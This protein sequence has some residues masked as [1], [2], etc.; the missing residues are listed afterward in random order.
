[1]KKNF[2]LAAVLLCLCLVCGS[3][4]A[5]PVFA[6]P[7]VII[8][9]DFENYKIDDVPEL[10]T[11]SHDVK[12]D[13]LWGGV[14]EDPDNP[15][16]KVMAISSTGT[17]VKGTI[18]FKP[19]GGTVSVKYKMR[20]PYLYNDC[21]YLGIMDG[22]V[23]ILTYQNTWNLW[24]GQQQIV[25]PNT[26]VVYDT[27]LDMEYVIR[28]DEQTFDILC[29]GTHWIENY[30]FYIADIESID[31]IYWRNG[32]NGILYI[33]DVVITNDGEIK[34]IY[35]KLESS[36]YNVYPSQETVKNIGFET[37]VKEFMSNMKFVE[38]A[39]V[40]ILNPDGTPY[41]GRYIVKNLLLDVSSPEGDQQKIFQIHSRPWM[42]SLVTVDYCKDAIIFCKNSNDAMIKGNKNYINPDDLEVMPFEE[43]GKIYLPLRFIAEQRGYTVEWIEDEE[44]VKFGDVKLVEKSS[45][46]T[47]NSQKLNV[48]GNC[49]NKNGTM[50]V[51]SDWIDEIFDVQVRAYKNFLIIKDDVSFANSRMEKLALNEIAARYN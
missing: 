45:S 12:A 42:A 23:R 13:G 5:A 40:K 8:N 19:L 22:I 4:A 7:E 11:V 30:K 46:V 15:D 17:L 32:A 6:E 50:Y 51:P 16:N 49:I 2:K 25:L 48:D 33:D 20:I 1:M 26:P 10:W 31:H 18:G 47:K 14:A 44:A 34:T 41:A 21:H 28:F 27:W 9:Q 37:P 3:F 35:T 38:G 39:V 29:N 24:N 36:A 43:K